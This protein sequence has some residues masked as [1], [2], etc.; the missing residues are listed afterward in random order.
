MASMKQTLA[1]T[2]QKEYIFSP[3]HDHFVILLDLLETAGGN[4]KNARMVK[5]CCKR[6]IVIRKLTIDADRRT[7]GGRCY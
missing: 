5:F 2:V 7:K 3:N 6:F 1:V 4:I